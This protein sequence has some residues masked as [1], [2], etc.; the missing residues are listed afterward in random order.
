M[1]T[2]LSLSREALITNFEDLA[3][4]GVLFK[5]IRELLA[6]HF[7]CN[8][9]RNVPRSCNSVVHEITRLGMSWTWGNVLFSQ[10]PSRVCKYS[11]CSR[12]GWALG[13]KSRAM[14]AC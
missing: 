8:R 7:I 5:G 12:F 13:C 11:I 10:T 4:E 2:D 3:L 1:E 14:R 9:I 6:D